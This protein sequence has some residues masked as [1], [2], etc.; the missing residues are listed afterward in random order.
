L[1]G[2]KNV[3]KLEQPKPTIGTMSG[4][5]SCFLLLF[6]DRPKGR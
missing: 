4:N 6:N 1:L 5:T 3:E 2:Q